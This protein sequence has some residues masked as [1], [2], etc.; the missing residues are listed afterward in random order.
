MWKYVKVRKEPRLPHS[1][2]LSEFECRS[3]GEL[4]SWE[5][6]QWDT[7]IGVVLDGY[8]TWIWQIDTLGSVKWMVSK[9]DL[10]TCATENLVWILLYSLSSYI[11]DVEAIL[12]GWIDPNHAL[13]KLKSL[14]VVV[15]ATSVL[16]CQTKWRKKAR[17]MSEGWTIIRTYDIHQDE[18]GG[19]TNGCFKVELRGGLGL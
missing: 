2:H 14:R 13:W 5:L 19:V 1:E 12:V 17:V 18:V 8:P 15:C 4:V 3:V 9:H 7:H 11:E 6:H 10:P 16:F